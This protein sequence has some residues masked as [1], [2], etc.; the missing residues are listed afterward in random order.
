MVT[1]V[2]NEGM[3]NLAVASSSGSAFSETS[4]VEGW[5]EDSGA[6]LL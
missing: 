2:G 3:L 1:I 4:F 6:S 5:F